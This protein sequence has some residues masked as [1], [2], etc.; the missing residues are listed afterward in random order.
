MEDH[1]SSLDAAFWGLES[2]E[3]PLRLGALALFGPSGE[4]GT[5]EDLAGLLA[6]RAMELPRLRQSVHHGWNPFDGPR[7]R[8]VPYFDAR[9]HVHVRRVACAGELREARLLEGESALA[10]GG[11]TE[12][13]APPW[14]LHV[15][16]TG[17]PA[18]DGFALLAEFHHAAV[19]GLRAMELGAALFDPLERSRRRTPAA[20]VPAPGPDEPEASGGPGML[21][22]LLGLADPRRAVGAL[23]GLPGQAHRT[24]RAAEIAASVGAAAVG[25]ALHPHA[26]P[27][28]APTGRRAFAFPTLPLDAVHRIRKT[29][30]GT[31]NDVLLA[32]LSSALRG[33]LLA[34]GHDPAA[35][36]VRVLV[37]VSSRRRPGDTRLGNQLSGHL[38]RLPLDEDDPLA[39]LHS[40]REAML[41]HKDRG[42]RRGA[43]AF[44]LLTDL[45]PP[46]A[47]RLAAP[48]LR[49]GAP[50]LFDALATNVPLPDIPFTLGG[51]PLRALHPLAPLARGHALA[52]AM[53][54]YRGTVHFGLH[55]AAEAELPLEGLTTALHEALRELDATV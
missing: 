11:G 4:T 45:V 10:A 7:W 24:R 20:S 40:V 41:E 54:P 48:L 42:P 43:G 6:E 49:D 1:L 55:G 5:E 44:A 27:L 47:H 29:H 9:F 39:R 8:D 37:P 16:S 31:A 26:S 36:P 52:V 22:G 3:A 25:N 38:V 13:G 33:W 30:G 53:T 17:R 50:L 18:E 21:S 51:A 19:D 2:R 14:R 23:R 35:R 34:A 46:A 32:V 28:H 15:F 12:R